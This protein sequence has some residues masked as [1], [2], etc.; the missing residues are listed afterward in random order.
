MA[1]K[2]RIFVGPPIMFEAPAGFGGS[3]GGFQERVGVSPDSMA[4]DTVVELYARTG[5]WCTTAKLI[6]ADQYPAE[7]IEQANNYREEYLADPSAF[8]DQPVPIVT[9]DER[10]IV[11][12]DALVCEILE[13]F[14]ATIVSVKLPNP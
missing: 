11:E 1:K 6:W 2:K 13:T 4:W 3:G 7:L 9:G 14:D 10:E 8:Y 12:G 5:E